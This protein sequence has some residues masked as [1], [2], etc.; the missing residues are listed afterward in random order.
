MTIQTIPPPDA[1]YGRAERITFHYMQH[2]DIPTVRSS[3]RVSG[4]WAGYTLLQSDGLRTERIASYISKNAYVVS[5]TDAGTPDVPGFPIINHNHFLV[6]GKPF[7]TLTDRQV[8][9]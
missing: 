9:S 2:A 3:C 7:E 5:F 6:S 4:G 8:K 1:C